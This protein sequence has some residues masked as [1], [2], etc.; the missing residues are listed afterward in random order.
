MTD[1]LC[2]QIVLLNVSVNH[3]RALTHTRWIK[4]RLRGRY[5][6]IIVLG[7]TQVLTR[8][9]PTCWRG[10][11]KQESAAVKVDIALLNLLWINMEIKRAMET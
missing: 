11:E 6:C 8:S 10:Q 7:H 1:P 9:N 4:V 3:W 5:L 2:L